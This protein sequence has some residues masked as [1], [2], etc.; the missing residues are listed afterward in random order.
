MTFVEAL[1]WTFEVFIFL[2]YLMILFS[3]I[4]DLFRDRELNGWFKALWFVALLFVP[5]ITALVYIIA[6]GKGMHERRFA[7][8]ADAQASAD[9]YIRSVAS[10][11]SPADHIASAKAL[12]DAGTIT[13]AEF[14]TLKAKALA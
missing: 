8:Y 2:A 10:A 1:W 7:A 14:E 13:P 6:R 5:V 11:T 12:L 9:A 3:I 4:Q